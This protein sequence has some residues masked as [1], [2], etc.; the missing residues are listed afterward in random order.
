MR[1]IDAQ[2]RGD[3]FEKEYSDKHYTLDIQNKGSAGKN[4]MFFLQDTLEIAIQMR[5]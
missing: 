3:F 5:M 4:F 1:V 2:G